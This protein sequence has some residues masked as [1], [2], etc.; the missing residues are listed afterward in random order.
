MMDIKE[1]RK[2]NKTIQ[3]YAER[4]KKNILEL[5]GKEYPLNDAQK[6]ILFDAILQQTDFLTTELNKS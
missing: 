2:I 4:G 1:I 6:I 3:E 5:N